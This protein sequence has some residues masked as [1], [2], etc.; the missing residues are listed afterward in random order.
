MSEW[1]KAAV[2]LAAA[3]AAGCIGSLVGR[4]RGDVPEVVGAKGPVSNRRCHVCHMFY[5]EDWLAVT[6]AKVRVGCEACH[7]SSDAHCNDEGNITPPD[8][9]F[10]RRAVNPLC[11]QCHGRKQLAEVPTHAPVLAGTATKRRHCTDC[12]G[13]HLLGE[14]VVRWDKETGKLLE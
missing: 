9:M 5:E 14:R 4:H 2:V 12:H 7:G 6:H 3:C 11:M 1:R 10:P 13:D 8:R